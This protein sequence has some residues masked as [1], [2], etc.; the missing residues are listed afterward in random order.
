MFR[1]RGVSPRLLS[2]FII[3]HLKMP[4]HMIMCLMMQL[5]VDGAVPHKGH[6]IS[7]Q[8]VFSMFNQRPDK[9]LFL[10]Q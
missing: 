7:D 8:W 5:G 1:D 2:A 6:A 4:V 10:M 9:L 3:N